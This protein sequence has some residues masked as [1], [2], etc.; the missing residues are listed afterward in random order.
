MRGSARTLVAA[1]VGGRSELVE[2]WL[3]DDGYWIFRPVIFTE[4]KLTGAFIVDID[5]REDSR[6]FFARVFCQREFMEH[7]LNPVVAQA[8]VALSR[9]KGTLRG[10]H[11]QFPPVAETKVVRVTRGAILDV[12]VDIRPESP[13][14]LQHVCVELSASN[15][16]ALFVPERFAHGFQVLEKDTETTY[17]MGEFY[18]PRAESGLRY[19]DPALGIVWPL[20]VTEISAKDAA[21]ELL[22]QVEPALRLRMLAA[23][24]E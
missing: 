9:M 6:G 22:E 18:T 21:W 19:S 24:I 7:G 23:D 8:N 16:R 17:L 12:I 20:P 2:I 14:Y 5:A 10:L 4:T 11:F 13:S 3:P 15:H 1:N